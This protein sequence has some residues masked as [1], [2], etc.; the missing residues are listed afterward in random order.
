MHPL[1]SLSPNRVRRNRPKSCRLKSKSLMPG[2]HFKWYKKMNLFSF[3]RFFFVTFCLFAGP[4]LIPVGAADPSPDQDQFKKISEQPVDLEHQKTLYVVGYAHLDTQWRWTYP[5]VIHEFIRNTM[6][7][8]FPL[9]DKYP[10]YVFN[11]TGSRRYEFMKEYYPDD[12]ARV[13]Q[14]VAAGRWF[15]AGSSVDEGD[16]II[17]GLESRVR[18]VLYGNRFFQREFHTQSDETMLPDTFG[19]PACLPSILVHCGMKGFSTQKLTWGSAVG[20]PF[21]VGVWEGVDGQKIVAA[22]NPGAYDSNINVDLSKDLTWINRIQ[23]DGDA[24]GVYADFRYYGIGDRGGATTEDTVKWLE[25]SVTGDGPLRVISAPA[26]RMFDDLTEAEKARLPV[27]KGELLLTGHS[28]GSLTSKAIMKRFNRKNELLANAAESAA[29]TAFEL[30]ALPYPADQLYRAWDLVLGSQMHDMLPGTCIPTA[31]EFTWNDEVLALNH[32]ASVAESSSAAVAAGMDTRVSPDGV[33]IVVYNPLSIPREDVVEAS[34]TLPVHTYP[35]I[36][37]YGPDGQAVPTQITSQL[38]NHATLLFLAKSPSVGYAVYEARPVAPP[39]FATQL[40]SSANAIE[41]ERYRVTLNDEGDVTSILDKTA[42]K[43]LLSSPAQLVFQYEKPYK[44]PSWNMDWN[45]RQKPPEAV[46]S[47]PAQVSVVESGPVRVTL[48]VK[49]SARGSTFTQ[50]IRLAAGGAGNRVEFATQINWQSL[51]CS[52]KASFPLSVSNP[53]ATYDAQLGTVQRGNNDPKKFEVPQQQ[54]MDLTDPDGGYGVSIL[55]DSKYGSDKPDDQTLRL[56]LL[57]S[58]GVGNSYQDQAT[59]DIG[60]QEMLYAVEGHEGDWRKGNTSWEAARLNQPLIA[61]TAPAHPGLLGKTFSLFETNSDQVQI[62]SIKKAEDSDEIVVRFKELCGNPAPG[63]QLK[64]ALPLVAAREINGQEM[65]V[66]PATLQAGA[67]CFDLSPYQLRAFALKMGALP[68]PPVASVSSKPL[69][70]PYNLDAVSSLKDLSDGDFDGRGHAYPAEQFPATVTSGGVSFQFGSAADGEKNALICHGQS[71][72]LPAGAFNRVYLLASAVDGDQR[73][74]LQV[75]GVSSSW[76]VQ[77]WSQFIGQW[78]KRLWQGE[79]PTLAYDWPNALNGLVPGYIKRAPVA[80]YCSHRHDAKQGNEFYQ[81]A[82]FFKYGVALPPGAKKLTLPN[83]DKIRVFAVSVANEP[84][85]GVAPAAPLYDTFSNHVSNEP[86]EAFPASGKFSDL[87]TVTLTP[88]LYYQESNLHYTT[89]GTDPTASSPVYKDQ[90]VLHQDALLKA[91]EFNAKGQPGPLFSGRYEVDDVSPPAVIAILSS[92]MVPK[93]IVRFSKSIKPDSA[94]NTNNYSFSVDESAASSGGDA[95][96]PPE[97]KV[98]S[99]KLSADKTTVILHV[100][101]PLSQTIPMKL[102]VGNMV[103][104]SA[105]GN[106]LKSFEGSVAGLQPIYSVSSLQTAND[107]RQDKVDGLPVRPDEPWTLNFFLHCDTAPRDHILLGGW[108]CAE[109]SSAAPGMGRYFVNFEDGLAFWLA[110]E[111]IKTNVKL[112]PHRWQMLTA[113]YDGK[114]VTLYKDDKK[115]G[116]GQPAL[117][118]DAAV[119]GLGIVDP[120]GNGNKFDGEIRNFQIWKSALTPQVLKAI[121]QAESP[122]N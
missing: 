23:K 92:P 79:V 40:K 31:Y 88:P 63:I 122:A 118:P 32:F 29:T 96:L 20:I 86:L 114:T 66:G 7:D 14:Y 73:G 3:P 22:L 46:V 113:T 87:V 105:K 9:F 108:G 13:Q 38:G 93:V 47:G 109:D 33:P 8:N 1:T 5:Q 69:S 62:V 18:Q 12:F 53:L 91:C 95:S 103:E 99:A 77:D 102:S 85:A 30:G 42:G 71:L 39:S 60:H 49:R 25:R 26:N 2:S 50:Q 56:T 15:P 115:I 16:T 61:F 24:T 67:L 82:Y 17:S 72:D 78:D 44:W 94:E 19:F 55:N 59:Q 80:W 4:M 10:N 97:V 11:F 51:E 104:A 28:A 116:E 117:A 75:G 58:P 65:P 100:N 111:D 36:T 52:L 90:I 106:I 54:W 27:Y 98:E 119:T 84:G 74:D 64:S 37:V 121:R 83:N 6:E 41:N 110:D 76:T 34:I 21:N 43:E 112:E 120:W 89:D 81:Y 45:D 107:S 57:Y 101:A 68:N 70:L 48:E 35:G